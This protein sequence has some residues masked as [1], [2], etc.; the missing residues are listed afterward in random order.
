MGF[1]SNLFGS[2]SGFS[3]SKVRSSNENKSKVRGDKYTHTGGKSHVHRSYDL[4]TASGSYREYSGGE[5]ASDRSYN[6]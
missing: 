6:K 1:W 4:D 2:H 5:N 3:T